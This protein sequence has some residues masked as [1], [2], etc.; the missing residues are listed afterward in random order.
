LVYEILNHNSDTVVQFIFVTSTTT[1]RK[2]PKRADARK[3]IAAILEAATECL[4]RDPEASVN[5]IAQAA[6]VGRVTL[7]GH[8]ESR[9][10]LVAQVVERAMRD[11]DEVLEAVDLTGDPR[12]ALGR[13]LDASWQVTHRYGGLV[14]AAQAALPEADFREAHDKP[15]Q[16][17]QRLLRRGRREGSFRS[18]MPVDWQVMT[19]QGVIHA[20]SGAVHRGEVTADRVPGLIRATVLAALTPPGTPVP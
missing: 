7:Y 11:G 14:L 20:A 12:A 16:R 8:F 5:D 13:L 10:A 18:D 4:A 9:G 2:T 19:I 17:V 6:G 3:N 15:A 1:G